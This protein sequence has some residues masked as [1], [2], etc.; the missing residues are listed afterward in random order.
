MIARVYARA[1]LCVPWQLS[2][3]IILGL[4][5]H[6]GM[7][8]SVRA[9]VPR[10]ARSRA[11]NRSVCRAQ[12]SHAVCNTCRRAVTIV[13]AAFVFRNAISLSSWGGIVLIIAGSASYAV[14]S[15][16]VRAEGAS[17]P[18]LCGGGG[19]GGEA[20]PAERSLLAEEAGAQRSD[21]SN[22]ADAER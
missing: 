15:A 16:R 1:R 10:R 13:A 7:R 5:V 19:A 6:A 4:S 17:S 9:C 18:E 8:A 21:S 2:D 22:E 12:V 11:A 3:D 20:E 14:A